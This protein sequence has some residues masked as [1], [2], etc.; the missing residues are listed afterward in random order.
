MHV[1]IAYSSGL[2]PSSVKCRDFAQS[3]ARLYYLSSL[4]WIPRVLL[5]GLSQ[6][7]IIRRFV[8]S[9]ARL[10]SAGARRC[11]VLLL[12][13][14]PGIASRERTG[15]GRHVPDG[16]IRCVPR[17]G[18][19]FGLIVLVLAVRPGL[20]RRLRR[21]CSPPLLRLLVASRRHRSRW[22]LCVVAVVMLGS[23]LRML[24]R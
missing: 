21:R 20:Y 10:R 16:S 12:R 6:V 23:A 2:D 1:T 11:V 5:R 8:V 13:M 4:V 24:R 15:T 18:G 19:P 14:R 22:K 9:Q 17:R 3:L 7:G